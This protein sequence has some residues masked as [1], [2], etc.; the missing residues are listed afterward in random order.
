MLS[1]LVQKLIA[2]TEEFIEILQM[3][4]IILKL[5][6]RQKLIV[7]MILCTGGVSTHFFLAGEKHNS[8]S[9]KNTIV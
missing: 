2:H 8:Y 5:C 9:R 3:Y 7:E 6:R 1:E 4:N